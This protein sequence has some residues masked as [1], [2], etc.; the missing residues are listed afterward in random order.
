MKKYLAQCSIFLFCAICFALAFSADWL[1]MYFMNVNIEQ[2]LFHLRFPLVSKSTP[3]IKD[4]CIE[5]LLPSLGLALLVV[6]IRKISLQIVL[7][8]MICASSMYIVESKF[9][10]LAYLEQRKIVSN[11]YENHYATFDFEN[12]SDFTPRQNLIII[13]AESL[14]STFSSANIPSALS[15]A[16]GG[17]DLH[18]QNLAKSYSPFGEL[19]PNL[20]NLARKNINFST[21][22]ALGG[23][24]QVAGTNWTIAGITGYLC[25]IPLNMPIYKNDFTHE[26]FLDS[27]ICV[28]DILAQVGYKQAIIAGT[29][30]SFAGK[31]GFFQSHNIEVM[32][33]PYFQAQN[34]MPNP[35]PKEIQGVW[36][37]KDSKMFE[38]AKNHLESLDDSQPF[39]L[40]LLSVDTHFNGF[41]DT[42]IC[43]GFGDDFRSMMLCND[44]IISDFVK[45]VQTSRFGTNTTI[46]I[47]GDHLSMAVFV[48]PDN[49]KR[50]VYNVFIN[51]QFTQKPTL[52]LT[53]NRK[54]SH[55]DITPLILD[56]LGITTKTF[57]LGRNPLY[58]K[59]LLESE[60]DLETLN[61]LLWQK[62]KIY[63]SFW[64]IKKK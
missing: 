9:E 2:I 5:V 45:W 57:G 43:K 16:D 28:S 11:L 47:L 31:R 34:I 4:F 17:G 32:D 62:N 60:F 50:F 7:S 3:F 22:N 25:G 46:I 63:D 23:I 59:T 44:K 18:S 12:F 36:D 14:E 10:I 15:N 37:L 33:L 27:A 6:Y 8:A 49:A 64:K 41:T 40:Y 26:Y 58:G 24:N 38:L 61:A 54:L 35:L 48:F 30:F 53:K 20:T 42:E 56:S 1:K 52:E 21:T 51:P 13:L 55:F 39:A 19:I 29:D